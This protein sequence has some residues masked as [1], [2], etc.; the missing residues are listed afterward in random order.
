MRAFHNL[1][2]FVLVN[3][4][5]IVDFETLQERHPSRLGK[6]DEHHRTAVSRPILAARSS[7]L[8]APSC[9]T[10]RPSQPTTLASS[11]T[12]GVCWLGAAPSRLV[13]DYIQS[14]RLFSPLAMVFSWLA[15]R[16]WLA[17]PSWLVAEFSRSVRSS[18][19]LATGFCSL[20]VTARL[21]PTTSSLSTRLASPFAAV[22]LRMATACR[23]VAKT[24][25]PMKRL[26]S[27]S[28]VLG[29]WFRWAFRFEASSAG[30][31]QAMRQ[32]GNLATLDSCRS[33]LL[34][35]SSVRHGCEISDK[36]LDS[37]PEPTFSGSGNAPASSSA[38]HSPYGG[39]LIPELTSLVERVGSV[40]P[41]CGSLAR[42]VCHG[43][44]EKF[45]H[46]HV[47]VCVEC[48]TPLCGACMDDHSAEGHWSDSDTAREMSGAGRLS[49]GGGR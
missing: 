4:Q 46:A 22:S 33:S 48:S 41:V 18:S 39:E 32:R 40:C 14:A 43:C 19:R 31:T 49:G 45:C 26:A 1:L 37:P 29:I 42:K 36:V 35:N 25:L 3:A 10:A 47:Y 38:E 15:A 21:F 9:L 24:F 11:F 12:T 27:G 34:G 16:S 20:A 13:A 2:T 6:V 44:G 7:R 30:V 17:T 5:P 8:R 23:L 28:C